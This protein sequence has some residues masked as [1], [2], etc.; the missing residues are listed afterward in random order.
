MGPVPKAPRASFQLL[1]AQDHPEL[2]SRRQP[3]L[4]RSPSHHGEIQLPPGAGDDDQAQ[5][6][7]VIQVP[8][9]VRLRSLPPFALQ[10]PETGLRWR[11][12]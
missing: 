10:P 3:R 11:A 7:G 2:L 1:T 12:S 6:E 5:M 4:F 9:T 8:S